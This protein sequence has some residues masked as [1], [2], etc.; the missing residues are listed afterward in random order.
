MLGCVIKM[1]RRKQRK[2]H[3]PLKQDIDLYR[4]MQE[5]NDFLFSTNNTSSTSHILILIN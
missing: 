2:I 4:R 1:P 3:A 5:N